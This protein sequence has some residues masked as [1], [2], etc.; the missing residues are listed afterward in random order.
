MKY[1]SWSVIKAALDENIPTADCWG[2]QQK[3]HGVST[4]EST[5]L[6]LSSSLFAL[7]ITSLPRRSSPKN[8]W[9][10]C[11]KDGMYQRYLYRTRLQN[12]SSDY[13]SEPSGWPTNSVCGFA[14][15]L[16]SFSV[17]GFK[18]QQEQTYHW[19]IRWNHGHCSMFWTCR[20]WAPLHNK[21]NP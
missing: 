10:R 7:P 14:V 17:A 4:C 2:W 19:Y 20:S 6:A 11:R 15:L 12:L 9:S 18:P 13:W 3:S 5:N 21:E 16:H 1:Y 8:Y